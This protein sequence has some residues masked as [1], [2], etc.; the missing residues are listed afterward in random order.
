MNKHIK[1]EHL[2]Q[3]N[4]DNCDFQ[5]T[6]V[7]ILNKHINLKHRGKSSENLKVFKCEVCGNQFSEYWSIMN[8]IKE[9][10]EVTERCT[11]YPRG[12]CK[13]LDEE[14]WLVH[15]KKKEITKRKETKDD[16]KCYI[17]EQMFKTKNDMMRHRKQIH[18]VG[19]RTCKDDEEGTCEF[20]PRRCWY[21]HVNDVE[22][23]FQLAP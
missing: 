21:I 11:H 14:C 4:C 6:N 19:L 5:A 16:S 13:F 22:Q 2:K 15:E 9:N 18:P 12:R 17:C 8:H 23:G 1:S 7:L 3:F 20:G 10:H